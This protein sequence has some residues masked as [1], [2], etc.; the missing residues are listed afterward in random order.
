MVDI[1]DVSKIQ[2]TNSSETYGKGPLRV[3]ELDV[4]LKII[5]KRDMDVSFKIKQFE[6]EFIFV[7][8]SAFNKRKPDKVKFAVYSGVINEWQ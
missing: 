6:I 7:L 4:K 5:R 2:Q 1:L 3:E 8:S